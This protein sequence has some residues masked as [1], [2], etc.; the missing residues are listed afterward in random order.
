MSGYIRVS[1][2]ISGYPRDQA[3]RV[4]QD[5]PSQLQIYI[6][7]IELWIFHDWNL[8]IFAVLQADEMVVHNFQLKYIIWF[9]S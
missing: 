4:Y 2:G 3:T 7:S 9:N 1:Q 5:I 6:F 8:Y